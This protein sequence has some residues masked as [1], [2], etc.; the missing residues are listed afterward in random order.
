MAALDDDFVRDLLY[1]GNFT[2]P[3]TGRLG[4]YGGPLRFGRSLKRRR[5]VE[6]PQVEETREAAPQVRAGQSSRSRSLELPRREPTAPATSPP[7]PVEQS[8]SRRPERAGPFLKPTTPEGWQAFHLRNEDGMRQA[9]AS[10]DGLHKQGST[11]YI[12]GTRGVSD[13]MDWWRIPT[14]TFQG[15]EI[16]KRAE[17]VF[18]AD[19]NIATVVGH[20]AGGTAALELEKRFPGRG[21][22]SVTY[23][24][25]VFSPMRA[26]QLRQEDRPLRFKVVGDPVAALDENAR[27]TWKAPQFPLEAVEGLAR[28]VADPNPINLL[29]ASR[30]RPDPLLGLHRMTDNYSN[31]SGPMDFA[32]SAADGVA[33]GL[34]AG[35]IE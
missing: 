10:P 26:D 20:S 24:A 7:A 25:P 22:T 9:Y 14:G 16:Y 18:K 34:A 8:P 33:M 4:P 28:A 11:L 27:T 35:M 13:V 5:V 17:P 1:A 3:L 30:Q 31:P 15:S 23:G 29:A 2:A 12:A 21:V 32:K 19:P 6:G